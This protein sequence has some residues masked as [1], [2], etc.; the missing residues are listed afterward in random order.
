M[1]IADQQEFDVKPV[2]GGFMMR[3]FYVFAALAL[4][5]VALSLGGRWLG[6]TIAAV[7]HASDTRA[8]EVVIANNVLK[9]PGNQ[10]RFERNRADGETH[11]LDLYALWPSM[12]GYSDPV[13]DEFNHKDGRRNII[14]ITLE[15]SQMSRDMSGRLEPIYRKLIDLPG[16][17]GPSGLRF[18]DF[19]AQSGYVNEKLAVEQP[20][21][22][23]AFVARCLTGKS[24]SES[25]ASCERDV[26]VTADLS[27]IYRFPEAMLPNWR[28]LDA[29][30]LARAAE[31]LNAAR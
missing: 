28:A 3:V 10:I 12:A 17:A 6:Q 16:T 20:A 31:F 14:F 5:S 26:Q 25:L 30:V 19:S 2:E 21:S 1:A 8:Y 7:G 13:R 9:V 4:L 22:G 15:P 23:E 27:L 24:A 29:A 11:R 18:Y